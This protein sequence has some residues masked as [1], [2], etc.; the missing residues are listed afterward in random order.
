MLIVRAQVD[1][2]SDLRVRTGA[3]IEAIGPDLPARPGEEILDARGASVIPGLHDHHLHLRAVL[4]ARESVQLSTADV[5]NDLRAAADRAAGDGWLRA[6][7]YHEAR[8]GPLDRD[9]LDSIVPE[10]PVRVLHRTGEMWVLNSRALDAVGASTATEPGLERDGGGRLTGRLMRMD[11]WLGER[12]GRREQ[13]DDTWRGLSDDALA[14]G[15]T[16][17]TDATA[18]R[19]QRDVAAFADLVDRTVVRQRLTLMCPPD[20]LGAP[21]IAVGP[22]KIV[23]DDV[24]LPSDADLAADIDRAHRRGRAVAIHCVTLDQL[25]VALAA[26]GRAGSTDRDRI[27]HASV[28]APA[29]VDAVRDIG[30]TVVTQPGLVSERGDD[31]LREVEPPERDWLYPCASL[32]A[33]GI[34]VAGATDAPHTEPDVWRAMVAAM[35]RRT[36]SGVV[37]GAGERIGRYAALDLFLGH[38]DRPGRP[39]RVAVGEPGEL[40]VLAAPLDDVLAAP[41][42]DAVASVVMDGQLVHSA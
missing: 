32:Q 20:V 21:G 18:G 9:V 26:F 29:M 41:S 39:R 37:L 28:V 27:E 36:A 40:C 16:G 3:S 11:G 13:A 23:L 7:G 38:P 12:V 34:P 2:R 4:A 24:T 10:R 1:G 8:S 15:V 30:V 5:G 14:A 42:R 22:Y 31:Y 35:H 19:D 17:W 6:V 33:A 25:T